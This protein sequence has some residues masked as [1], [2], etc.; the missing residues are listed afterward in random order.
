MNDLRGLEHIKKILDDKLFNAVNRISEFEA[1]KIQEVRLRLGKN[2]SVCILDKEYFVTEKGKLTQQASEG[3]R[4]DQYDID[5][6]FS[7]ACQ[8]SLHSFQKE[9]SQGYITVNGGNRIGI[10]GTAV[11]KNDKVET[12]KDISS[13][14]IRVARQII[15][16]ADEIYARLFRTEIQ[17]VLIVGVPS[18]GKTT[19]LRD[20]CRQL[21]QVRKVSI[22]D[23]RNELSATVNGMP[24]NDVGTCSD[25]FNSYPKA[26]GIITAIRVMSPEIIVCD[27]IGGEEDVIALQNAIHSGVKIIA[28]AHAGSVSEARNRAGLSKLINLGAFDSI[29]L[30]G[31]GNKIGQIMD[32]YKMADSSDR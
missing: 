19:I 25:I 7:I 27:E 3:I 8:Y 12:I 21:G 24:Q 22:I 15:G 20:L 11:I 23:E 17:S 2:L 13:L 4:I 31:S 26:E 9:L 14:N 28:T 6:T 5:T 10:C 16:C 18:S 30:L 29:V 32:I 1:S